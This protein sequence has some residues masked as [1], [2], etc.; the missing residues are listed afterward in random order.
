MTVKHLVPDIFLVTSKKFCKTLYDGLG[1]GD[2]DKNEIIPCNNVLS[3]QTLFSNESYFKCFTKFY[4][5]PDGL[6]VVL[7][8][9]LDDTVVFSVRLRLKNVGLSLSIFTTRLFSSSFPTDSPRIKEKGI[10]CRD[11]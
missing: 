7:D 1:L 9:D 2:N 10:K 6:S 11:D 3:I 5:N 8:V 4:A